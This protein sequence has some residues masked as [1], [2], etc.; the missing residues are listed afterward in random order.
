[1]PKITARKLA[2]NLKDLIRCFEEKKQ[3]IE[4]TALNAGMVPM[5]KRIFGQGISGGGF[6]LDGTS[7]GKYSPPYQRYRVLKNKGFNLTKN[8]VFLS[9]IH[10]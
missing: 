10:I 7:L 5:I 4:V 9:L 1:M 3:T 6:A 8:L 2:E